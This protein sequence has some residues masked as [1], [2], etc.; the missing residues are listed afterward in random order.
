[1]PDLFGARLSQVVPNSPAYLAGFR[2]DDVI[3]A[4]NDIE[5]KEF[6]TL[7]RLAETTPPNETVDVTLLRKGEIHHTKVTLGELPEPRN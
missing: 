3:R 1:L 6:K 5:I 2:P 4:W 7:F